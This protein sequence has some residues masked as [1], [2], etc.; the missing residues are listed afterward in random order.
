[1]RPNPA[2]DLKFKV[3][4]N[5]QG[6][7]PAPVETTSLTMCPGERYEFILNFTGM[8]GQKVYMINEAGAPFPNGGNEPFAAGSPYAD[9]ATIMRFDVV[10]AVQ[11]TVTSLVIPKILDADFDD[12]TKLRRC[13]SNTLAATVGQRCIAAVRNLYLTERVDGTTGASLG[14]Q[15]NGVPFEYDVTETPIKGTYEQWNIINLTV[16]AHPMHPHLGRFQIVRRQDIDVAGY[17]LALCQGDGADNACTPGTAP[18]GVMQ[19]IPDPTPFLQGI[20]VRPDAVEA[21]WKDAMRAVPGQVLTFVGKWDGAW[22]A[23][24][25]LAGVTAPG[26]GN[27]TGNVGSNAANWSYPDVTS[28]PYVWHCHI[29]SHEDSEM[30]RTSLVVKP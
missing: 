30:M 5:E 28:G 18:G 11:G 25:T 26:A 4:A 13:S 12:V 6:Y 2:R 15:I 17:K 7:L 27:V 10:P 9:L 23:A 3:V 8:A 19:L 16:D 1:V 21:G 29:N 24:N 20:A 22:K 14:L